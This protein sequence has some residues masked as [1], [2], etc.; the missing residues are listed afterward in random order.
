LL[1]DDE[2]HDELL[3]RTGLMQGLKTMSG[4]SRGCLQSTGASTV[5]KT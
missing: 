5:R 2:R 1:A 4:S 3:A